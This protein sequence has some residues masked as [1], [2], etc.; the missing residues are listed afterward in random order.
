MIEILI[1]EACQESILIN[2]N[3]VHKIILKI[4]NDYKKDCSSLTIIISNDIT[5]TK[6]KKDFF[7]K[8]VLTDVITFNLEEKNQPIEGEVYISFERIVENAK[9]FN[10]Q[11]STELCRVIIHGVLHLIGFDD[12]TNFEK[13][14]MTNLENKYLKNVSKIL[15]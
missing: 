14:K 3:I 11:I 10:E 9:I 6:L 4:F 13:E 2:E 5:L 12:Q 8:D 15:K 7:N 1:D